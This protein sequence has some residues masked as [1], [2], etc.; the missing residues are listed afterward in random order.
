MRRLFFS[1]AVFCFGVIW[2]QSEI[3]ALLR[4]S[5]EGL[6]GTAR[7]K[8]LSGAFGALGGDL[9]AISINP[10]G[11]SVFNRG[12]ISVSVDSESNRNKA[13]FFGSPYS[14]RSS[15]FNAN[16]FGGVFV[17]KSGS[18]K[19]KSAFSFNYQR[20]RNYSNDDFAYGGSNLNASLVDFFGTHAQGFQLKDLRLQQGETLEAAY[21]DI[22]VNGSYEMLQAFLGFQ[23]YLIEPL[24]NNDTETSYRP[25]AKLLLPANQWYQKN[26]YGGDNKITLNFSFLLDNK[27]HIGGSLNSYS[28]DYREVTSTIEEAIRPNDTIH[29]YIDFRNEL[30]TKGGGFSLQI[31]SIYKVTDELRIGLAYQS[32]IWYTLKDEILQY[33]YTEVLDD[34]LNLQRHSVIPFR[35]I[36]YKEYKFRTPSQWLAS[37]AYVFGNYGLISVDFSYKDYAKM[38]YS[39]LPFSKNINDG[40]DNLFN[41]SYS[42]RIGGELKPL[43]R[44]SLRAGYRFEQSPYKDD[45]LMG[46]LW[47]CSLGLGYAF[48]RG[49]S[50]DVSYDYSQRSYGYR[51]YNV[52]LTDLAQIQTKRSS[53]VVTALFRLY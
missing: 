19:F 44:L 48:G 2:G 50:V 18:D 12:V 38:K 11:S 51:M 34:N 33:L 5:Q 23:T 30:N 40:I 15:D 31:G 49:L 16:Q 17:F 1:L 42:S 28:V 36:A 35:P 14:T 53:F 43:P 25:R 7:Y 9:S 46:D 3:E 10:A 37:M 8:A 41:G 52:G 20:V 27:I 39:E 4:F 24:T 26:T 21:E 13:M 45:A 6:F 22:A 32:P 47:G 29:Q